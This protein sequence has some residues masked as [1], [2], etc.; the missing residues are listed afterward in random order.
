MTQRDALTTDGFQVRYRIT[1][2][3]KSAFRAYLEAM[4]RFVDGAEG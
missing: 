3:G 1:N 2:E 4:K